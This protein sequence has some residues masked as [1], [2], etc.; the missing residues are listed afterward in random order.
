MQSLVT[1]L[2]HLNQSYLKNVKNMCGLKTFQNKN[3]IKSSKKLNIAE[4]QL[5]CIHDTH[6][7]VIKFNFYSNELKIFKRNELEK[8]SLSKD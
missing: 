6:F 5:I 1:T 7:S 4:T 8:F 3:N 2:V